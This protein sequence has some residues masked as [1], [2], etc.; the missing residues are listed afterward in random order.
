MHHLRCI[1]KN[2]LITYS[3]L[4]F[5]EN[6][7]QFIYQ[8][9]KTSTDGKTVIRYYKENG[10]LIKRIRNLLSRTVI[11]YEKDIAFENISD[12]KDPNILEKFT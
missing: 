11:T 12:E 8:L 1:L 7:F 4:E 5:F 6:I 3:F 2:Y 10:C 9:L